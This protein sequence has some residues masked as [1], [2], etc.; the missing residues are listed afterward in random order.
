MKKIFTILI[1]SLFA[2]SAHAEAYY[3]SPLESQELMFGNAL[4]WNTIWEIDMQKF[5]VEKSFDGITFDEIATIDASGFSN[6]D[7]S[8]HFLDVNPLGDVSYYR[9]R[10]INQSG[11]FSYSQIITA[12]KKSTNDLHLLNMS[13]VNVAS[14][15]R[16]QFDAMKEL[17]VKCTL[18]NLQGK[19]IDTFT[20]DMI[21]G[22]NEIEFDFK[23]Q[24]PGIYFVEVRNGKEKENFI[25][26]RTETQE[27]KLPPVADSRLF[28]WK[29]K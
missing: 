16:L 2:I 22:L 10:E 20:K 3:S 21:N 6:I 23:Q 8:Y 12:I 19:V 7:K 14:T 26:M 18:K 15:F 4:K 1:A 9:L 17:E 29:N 5:V 13:D 27:T 11:K 24:K 28:N 25:V